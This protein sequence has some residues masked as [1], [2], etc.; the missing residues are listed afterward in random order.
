MVALTLVVYVVRGAAV[1]SR[2]ADTCLAI[3]DSGM[4]YTDN[5]GDARVFHWRTTTVRQRIVHYTRVGSTVR[6]SYEYRLTGPD[7][8][9]SLTLQQSSNLAGLASP[10]K[11]GPEIQEGV[12]RARLPVALRT[13]ADGGTVTFGP[14][15]VDSRA[16][17]ARG[18][19]VPWSDIE[20][21]KVVAGHVS[22]RVAGRWL[23]LI[24]T[25]VSKIPNFFVFHA[26]AEQLRTLAGR[27]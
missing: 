22:L 9:E 4:V 16:V 15:E 2:H 17:T 8:R 21:I 12:T 26:L 14:I 5:Q 20:Q 19:C 6:T 25:E 23:S 27:S 10:E 11:W 13:V 1:N 7:G 3:F 18:S 24:N